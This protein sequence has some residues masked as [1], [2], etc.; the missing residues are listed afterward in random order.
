MNQHT[1]EHA[2][3]PYRIRLQDFLYLQFWITYIKKKFLIFTLVPLAIMVLFVYTV[4]DISISQVRLDD[5]R[6]LL[7]AFFFVV[8]FLVIPG[9]LAARAR[10]IYRIDEGLRSEQSLRIFSDG[11]LEHTSVNQQTT[12][13]ASS[14]QKVDRFMNHLILYLEDSR[15]IYVP[16]YSF[17]REQKKQLIEALKN[18]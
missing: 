12:Y 14:V 11:R 4:E 10:D 18:G 9:N 13:P 16:L 8:A 1:T 2:A 15:I 5:Y 6:F 17:D 7:V 3:Y